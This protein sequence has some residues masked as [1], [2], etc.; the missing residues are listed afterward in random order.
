M[1][2]FRKFFILLFPILFLH[3]PL[4]ALT[5]DSNKGQLITSYMSGENRILKAKKLEIKGKTKKAKKLYKEAFRF[6]LKANKEKPTD[7]NTLNYLGY[8]NRKLGNYEDAEIYYL[9]GLDLEPNHRGLNEY[10]GELYVITGRMY[11]AE[12][13]LEFLKNCKCEEYKQ[14]KEII[15]DTKKTKY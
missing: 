7:P 2:M 8:T 14:L 15:E 10:L 9:L 6:L 4:H 11:K 5:M 1:I 3:F 13:K 12:E